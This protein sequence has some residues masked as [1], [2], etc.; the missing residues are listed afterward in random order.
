MKKETYC[1]RCEKELFNIDRQL[2][3][4]NSSISFEIK[5]GRYNPLVSSLQTNKENLLN[6]RMKI[7]KAIKSIKSN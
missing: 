5:Y 4:I 1:D 3:K 6:K 2:K 7:E